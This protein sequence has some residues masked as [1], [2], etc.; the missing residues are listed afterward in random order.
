[1]SKLH[2]YHAGASRLI[3]GLLQGSKVMLP[4]P[5]SA[6]AVFCGDFLLSPSPATKYVHYA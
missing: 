5:P 3:E 4:T 6:V 1:M 2:H